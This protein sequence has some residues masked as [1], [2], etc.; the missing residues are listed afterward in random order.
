MGINVTFESKEAE[1]YFYEMANKYH[2]RHANWVGN[3]VITT[4]SVDE[5]VG[6]MIS[7]HKKKQSNT[8]L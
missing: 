5:L 7:I 3:T 4:E 6:Y 2:V 1:H 8:E